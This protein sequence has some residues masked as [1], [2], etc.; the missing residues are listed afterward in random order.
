M[1]RHSTLLHR[2]MNGQHVLLMRS[3]DDETA[4]NNSNDLVTDRE[5]TP[6]APPFTPLL[7]TTRP[8]TKDANAYIQ[9]Q[10]YR[11]PYSVLSKPTFL[12]KFRAPD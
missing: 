8:A 10:K 3:S 5:L 12:A 4:T 2:T 1:S 6:L 7:C 9:V 11:H